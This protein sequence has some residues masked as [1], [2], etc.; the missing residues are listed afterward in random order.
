MNRSISLRW[1]AASVFIASSTL[2]YLDRALLSV[3]I[4]LIMVDLHF[5]QS[6][7]GWILSVFSI[8]YAFASLF[9]G[10]FL[11]LVGV[12]RGMAAAVA[13]WSVAASARGLVRSF[14]GL[15]GTSA[16]LAVGESA[17]VPAVGKTN[18]NY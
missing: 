14:A 11:D 5:S 17:G 15:A 16:A 3:L 13:W 18:G 10:W 7:Y 4:P 12:N 1:V 8:V 2:N 9:A 6:G